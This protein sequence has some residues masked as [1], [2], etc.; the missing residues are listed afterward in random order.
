M[1]F[2]RPDRRGRWELGRMETVELE[3]AS[4]VMTLAIGRAAFGRR[5]AYFLF[6]EGTL[7]TACLSKTSEIEGFVEI[8][9]EI[10]RSLVELPGAI[11]KVRID[12]FKGLNELAQVQQALFQ[13]QKAQMAAAAGGTYVPP[14]NTSKDFDDEIYK[15]ALA[16]TASYKMKTDFGAGWNIPAAKVEYPTV[17]GQDLD[18]LCRGDGK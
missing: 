1:I 18:R 11:F 15:K 5:S 7:L 8:P 10:S 17:L 14:P 4:P 2:Q 12:Q 16:A 3:N 6:D 9:L 13:A